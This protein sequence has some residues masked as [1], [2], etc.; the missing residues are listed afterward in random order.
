MPCTICYTNYEN[1]PCSDKEYK[2]LRTRSKKNKDDEIMFHRMKKVCPCKEC[3]VKMICNDKRWECQ[4]YLDLIEK[5]I[6]E[7]YDYAVSF[8]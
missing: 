3:L 2:S 1:T 5:V 4:P 7:D 6:D 8:M